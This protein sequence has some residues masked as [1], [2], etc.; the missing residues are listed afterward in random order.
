MKQLLAL[1]LLL[2]AGLAQR[3]GAWTLQTQKDPITDETAVYAA[4]LHREFQNPAVLLV[5]CQ[6]NQPDI[7]LA[8]Q[9]FLSRGE[10]VTVYRFD[11]NTPRTLVF[12]SSTTGTSAFVPQDRL[13]VFFRGLQS[14]ARLALRVQDSK[15]AFHTYVFRLSGF[16]RIASRFTCFKRPAPVIAAAKPPTVARP[17]EALAHVNYIKAAEL[18]GLLGFG[19]DRGD[20]GYRLSKGAK[21]FIINPGSTLATPADDSAAITLGAPP[22]LYQGSLWLP[23]RFLGQFGCRIT[24]LE[25]KRARVECGPGEASSLSLQPWNP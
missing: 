21:G 3:Y 25:A 15:G 8:T 1:I 10:V 20:S 18:R 17:K 9:Q 14:S 13:W 22:L 11:Q 16:R 2:G 23:L 6:W 7:F 19:L 4:S 5:R 24:R 12:L